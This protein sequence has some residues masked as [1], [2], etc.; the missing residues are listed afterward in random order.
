MAATRS[1]NYPA[2]DLSAALEAI[3][4]ALRAEHRNKMSKEMLARH[5]GYTSLN[6]RALAKIGAVRAYG[7]IEGSGDEVRVS[8][9]ALHY[10][11]APPGAPDQ[12]AVLMRC[13]LRP[14]IFKEIATEFSTL[15]SE[16]NLRFWLIKRAYT[17]DAASKAA[18]S[19]LATMQLVGSAS[20]GEI[21]ASDPEPASEGNMN[22]AAVDSTH[23]VKAG[24]RQAIFA[25]EEGDV[26]LTFPADLTSDGYSELKEYLDIFLR[27]AIAKGKQTSTGATTEGVQDG[28]KA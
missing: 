5:L 26:S 25:L 3:K 19:Y 12:A 2:L 10:L 21:S 1:P 14:A 6:G 7:L 28:T 17:P 22:R 24:V 27:R 11:E 18:Q 13:A 16:P 23:Q 8:E 4:P 20:N 15:P 9:D